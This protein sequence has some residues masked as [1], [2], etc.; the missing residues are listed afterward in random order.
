MKVLQIIDSLGTG[1]AEKLIL[2]SVPLYIEQGITTDVLVL[3]DENYPFMQQLEELN[4]CKVYKLGRGS[5]YHPIHILKIAEILP[6]YDIAHVHLFPAQYW[7]VLAKKLSKAKTKLI[8]TEHNTSNKRINNKFLAV[9]D[10]YF[11]SKYDKIVSISK[12]ID[13]IIKRHTK[14][15]M[16]QVVFKVIEN[17]V[18]LNNI[19]EAEELQELKQVNQN[20]ILQVSA[21][22]PQ[23]D[24]KTLINSFTYLPENTILLLAGDGPL[25][26]GLEIFTK[27]LGL[28]ERI[29][30]LGNRS[31]IPQLLKTADVIVLSSHYEGMSL[32][33]IE[34]MASGRPF[35][36]SDVPGLSEI[37]SDA[38]LLFPQGNAKLLAEHIQK[39]LGNKVLYDEVVE[40]CQERA[41]EYDISIMVKK[42]IQLYEEVLA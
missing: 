12:E 22:R 13:E 34:G 1:G 20:I 8:F 27:E 36:A 39:L 29:L 25:K 2:D 10:R 23:K 35:I 7:A 32:S 3:R 42:Y 26:S 38:G 11:Y 6:K 30:F 16:S 33:S 18:D 40:K 5:V 17:G 28:S 41:E 9:I 37:V 19:Y 15:K 31:D 24:Q 14:L 21:F 4:I